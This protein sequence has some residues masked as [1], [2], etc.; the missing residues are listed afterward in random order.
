[1]PAATAATATI[2]TAAVQCVFILI[3][4]TFFLNH[5]VLAIR[6]GC[7][8]HTS[9]LTLLARIRMLQCTRQ[10]RVQCAFR[11]P[12]GHDHLTDAQQRAQMTA[13]HLPARAALFRQC[14][15]KPVFDAFSTHDVIASQQH[16]VDIRIQ[17]HAALQVM[18]SKS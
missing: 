6:R 7:M 18:L 13:M 11:T 12:N 3:R 4:S 14:L 9:L 17:A 8:L 10:V 5:A 1:M 16:G 2:A 15:L